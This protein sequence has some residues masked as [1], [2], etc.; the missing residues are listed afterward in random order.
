MI[1][2]WKKFNE[3]LNKSTYLSAAAEADKRGLKGLS[4]RFK[5]HGDQFGLN[6]ES[7][8]ITFSQKNGKQNTIDIFQIEVIGN[9]ITIFGETP[10][11]KIARYEGHSDNIG[12]ELWL[13]GDYESLPLTRQDAK[14]LLKIL[15]KEGINCDGFDVRSIT[16]NDVWVL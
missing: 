10:E 13:N 14:K 8:Q 9:E 4:N 2:N 11:G 1:N 15:S 3:E 12:I 6:P 16:A 7:K 5:E